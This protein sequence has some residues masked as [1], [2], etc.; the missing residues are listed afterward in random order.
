MG[1]CEKFFFRM[2]ASEFKVK[3]SV[4]GWIYRSDLMFFLRCPAGPFASN[5]SLDGPQPL[6]RS[7]IG[8][9]IVSLQENNEILVILYEKT[10]INET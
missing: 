3:M 5:R 1:T 4:N 2:S 10:E 6:K 9:R 7:K 8:D